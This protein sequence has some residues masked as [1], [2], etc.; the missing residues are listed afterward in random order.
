[1]IFSGLGN[2]TYVSVADICPA[3]KNVTIWKELPV[4]K[5]NLQAQNTNAISS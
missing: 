2:T 4:R 5:L 1:M 3:I